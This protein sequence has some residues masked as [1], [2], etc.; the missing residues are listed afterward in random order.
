MHFPFTSSL[1]SFQP[2]I[3]NCRLIERA[4]YDVVLIDCPPGAATGTDRKA[5]I[6][7]SALLA[8]HAVLMPVRPTP[9]DYQAAA[10]ILPLLQDVSFLRKDAPL[11]VLLVMNGRPAGRTRLGAEAH[12]AAEAIFATEGMPISVLHTE[13]CSRQTFAGVLAVG[14]AVIDY[15]P[16][17]K[18]SDELQQLAKRYWK[19]SNEATAGV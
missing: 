13:I 16:Q 12:Q 10:S 19:C 1:T 6:T 5:D 4:G 18:A 3:K 14:H 8:S 11:K 15:A 7:R 9:L 17:S 2:F